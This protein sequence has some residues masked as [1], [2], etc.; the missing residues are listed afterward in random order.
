[1]SYTA[2]MAATSLERI[3]RLNRLVKRLPLGTS[4]AN[5]LDSTQLLALLEQAYGNG[6]PEAR[7]RALQ[8]DL[9]DLVK[10]GLIVPVNPGGKPLRYRRIACDRD[11]DPGVLAYDLQQLRDWV[12]AAV[13]K[14]RLDRLWQRLLTDRTAL[15]RRDAPAHRPGHPAPATGGAV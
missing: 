4:P 13:P 10:D 2:A 5:C 9:D 11:D 14:R 15:A 8:R 6:S 1:M 7:R 3:E 12:T